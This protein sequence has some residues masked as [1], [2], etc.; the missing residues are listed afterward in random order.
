MAARCCQSCDIRYPASPGYERCEACGNETA[1][2]VGEMPQPDWEEKV[3]LLLARAPSL[4]EATMRDWRRTQLARLGFDG[5]LL[6]LL[7]EQ[8]TDIHLA[9]DL[10]GRGCPLVTAA[11]ILL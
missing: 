1:Y 2:R 3:E 10:V 6:D 9:Q 4:T 5:A 8:H 11:R 7:A